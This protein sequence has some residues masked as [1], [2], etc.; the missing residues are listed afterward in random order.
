[1]EEVF[2][3]TTTAGH[4][5]AIKRGKVVPD[6]AVN[7]AYAKV[8]RMTPNKNVIVVDTSKIIEENQIAQGDSTR[9]FYANSLGMLVDAT[10]NPIID[11]EYPIISDE[12]NVE[13]DITGADLSKENALP[14][15]HTSRYFHADYTGLV[16]G[17]GVVDYATDKIK[18]IDKDGHS[19]LDENGKPR[20]RV[21]ITPAKVN[22]PGDQS[23]YRVLVYL[24]TDQNETLYLTY[25]KVELDDDGIFKD[26]RINYTEILNPQPY[27]EY[28]P[29]ESEVVDSSA[30]DKKIYSTKPASLKEQILDI[31]SPPVN[32]YKAFVPKKAVGDPRIFQMFRWRVVCDFSKSYSIT[33][34]EDLPINVGVVVTNSDPN[35]T[36]GRLFIEIEASAAN[37][38]QIKFANPLSSGDKTQ[39]NYWHVNLDTV[40]N[41][42]LARF[43]MLVWAPTK[44]FDF[45]PYLSKLNYFV[46]S[47]GHK[48]FIDTGSNVKAINLDITATAPQNPYAASAVRSPGASAERHDGPY[49]EGGPLG[50]WDIASTN[51][52]SHYQRNYGAGANVQYIT[53]ST[54]YQSLMDITTTAYETHVVTSVVNTTQHVTDIYTVTKP[55]SAT[56]EGYQPLGFDNSIAVNVPAVPNGAIFDRVEVW[57][58]WRFANAP[59]TQAISYLSGPGARGISN[60]GVANS[61]GIGEIQQSFTSRNTDA[62]GAQF[63]SKFVGLSPGTNIIQYVI[64]ATTYWHYDLVVN[65]SH[66]VVIPANVTT[67][68]SVPVNYT[69]PVIVNRGN[70]ILSTFGVLQSASEGL[71]GA[72]EFIYNI[73]LYAASNRRLYEIE[74]PSKYTSQYSFSTNW[75]N[76]WVINNPLTGAQVLTEDEK[77]RYQFFSLPKDIND[78]QPLWQRQLTSKTCKQLIDSSLTPDMLQRIAGLNRVYRIEVT[79]TQ[80]DTTPT[81]GDNITPYAWTTAWTPRFIVPSD[82]GTY[83][84]H[85]EQLAAQL[86]QGT[87]TYRTYPDKPYGAQVRAVYLDSAEMLTP[88]T[89][90]WTATGVATETYDLVTTQPDEHIHEQVVV[91]TP[92]TEYSQVTLNWLNNSNRNYFRQL[93]LPYTGVMCP[94]GLVT[95]QE[96]NY[97]DA[98]RQLNWPYMGMTDRYQRGMSGDVVTFIQDALNTFNYFTLVDNPSIGAYRLPNNHLAIDGQYGDETYNAVLAFQ[99]TFNALYQDGVIDAETWSIIGSQILRWGLRSNGATD[100]HRFYDFPWNYMPKQNISDGGGAIWAKR[101]WTQGGPSMIWES[102]A[103]TFNQPFKIHAVGVIPFLEGQTNSLIINAVDTRLGFPLGSLHHYDPN[104]AWITNL[105]HRC[106]SGVEDYTAFPREVLADTIIVTVG[107]DGPAWHNSRYI[108]IRDIVAYATISTT[109]TVDTVQDHV[110]TIPGITTV[111]KHSRDIQIN[112]SG[113]ANNLATNVDFTVQAHPNYS[114]S[115]TLSNLRWT[116]VSV[117]NINVA[118]SIKPSG[119]IT[120]RNNLSITQNGSGIAYGI[121][122]P[123]VPDT[124]SMTPE[125]KLNPMPETGW[126]SKADGVKLLVDTH[127]N[128]VGFPAMP[129]AV[130]SGNIQRHYVSLSLTPFNT[131]TSWVQLGFWD[132]HRKEFVVNAQGLPEMPYTE[133]MDRGPQNIFIGIISTYELDSQ[134]A[135]PSQAD[136]PSYLPNLWAMPVYGVTTRYGG[137]ITLE[138]LPGNLG[139]DDV[140]PVAVRDGRFNRS[141]SVRKDQQITTY[142]QRYAGTQV[143][144]YYGIPEARLGGW[145]SIYGAPNADVIG[146]EPLIQDDNVIQVRQA[147]I[148]MQR[149]PYI[150]PSD[151]DPVRPIFRVYQRTTIDS[152]W[153]EIPLSEIFDYNVSTGEIF[154]V[155]PLTIDDP[156]LLRVDYTTVRR[157]YYFKQYNNAI[158][159]L[160]PYPGYS[161]DLVGKAIYVYIVPEYVKD[162]TG[163]LIADSVQTRALRFTT[164]PAIFDPFSSL[165]DPLAVELG[166]VYMSTALDV[167]DLVLIDS[168]RRGGGAKDSVPN[169][170]LIKLIQEASTYWDVNYGSGMLYQK[171]GYLIVRLPAALKN[172]FKE[173]EIRAAIERNITVGVKYDIEDL[174]GVRWS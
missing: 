110:I 20:Y 104:G 49:Y 144:A 29:E 5:A 21:K 83:V 77:E 105:W 26:Q 27:Y 90:H 174:N 127:K 109:R 126:I 34:T 68:F 101:S 134:H 107:Q 6:G 119:V 4:E 137:R 124:Y 63:Q 70:L 44:N 153:V 172:D 96:N 156:S 87:Y 59:G 9:L 162:Q 151:A 51:P 16:L 167:K 85:D 92:V 163:A 78:P 86:A 116:A 23:A 61:S 33:A 106:P 75:F 2:T 45:G 143:R 97:Y 122:M 98:N 141:V 100:Y 3:N 120:L 1:M 121:A 125:R 74:K 173:D 145:S 56:A 146:E 12:F 50:G 32:G 103:I 43:D 81:L 80:V 114:G 10:G 154:L 73:A 36:A 142:L 160:N 132:N 53:A 84:I 166:V 115:S 128:P 88:Q 130:G 158:L 54:N 69:Y 55:G 139:A 95:W 117:D 94:D 150:F 15:L 102:F 17:S 112:A 64:R 136:S 76:S 82:I 133:Y 31:P 38:S 28:K 140:W 7:L 24:D 113:T 72:Q 30:R 60:V 171:G 37:N 123:K 118:A 111:T 14:F 11:D 170:A 41:T 99:R 79:N 62:P 19:Y 131:D 39:E 65:A 18:V 135:F 71:S 149:E 13:G 165:Y 164:D 35:S 47:L 25:N 147:P 159:N 155:N 48:L 8:P 57:V 157:H 89:A 152:P 46:T 67:S 58:D 52:I 129:V 66:D 169:P 148:H 91:S 161:Q 108:G 138:S 93:S 40:S 22:P 42:D 168:R